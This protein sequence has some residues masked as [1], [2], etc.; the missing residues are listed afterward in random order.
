M[1]GTHTV[2]AVS[3]HRGVDDPLRGFGGIEFRHGRLTRDASRACVFG[4]GGAIDQQ[5]R[6]VDFDRHI[7][8][9]AL[10]HLQIAKR[11]A[12]Q[13]P[14][15]G[16]LHGF[17]HGAARKA[18]RRGADRGAEYVEGRHRDL[19]TVAGLA[20]QRIGGDAA[21][22]EFKPRQRMRRDDLDTLGDR[23]AGIIAFD[24][25]GRQ[26]FGAGPL[27]AARKHNIDIGNTAVRDPAFL[28]VEH[29]TIAVTLCCRGDIGDVGAGGRFGQSESRDDLAAAR[30]RQP[31]PALLGAAE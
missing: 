23:E 3:L 18:E 13:L 10:H 9:M 25:E 4:P 20:D 12:E 1:T 7:G 27:A 21:F 16:S 24:D 2:A 6:G 5:R 17:S 22:V 19:E 8:D 30:F 14:A 15:R 29:I 11:R 26:P 31:G 28:A